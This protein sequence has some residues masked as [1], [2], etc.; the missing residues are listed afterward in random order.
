MSDDTKADP[1][2]APESSPADEL[3][4]RIFADPNVFAD[5]HPL[6]RSLREIAPVYESA[7][8][9]TW[10]L[11][12]YEDCRALLRDNR[13]G[14]AEPGAETPQSSLSS[15]RRR[16]RDPEMRSILFMN[17][18][19]HT[20]IRSLVSRAFTP[21][22]V[23][24]LRPEVETIADS[25]IDDFASDGPVNLLDA[26]AFPLPAN[27]ISALVGVPVE[28]RDW[29]R[30]L[31]GNLTASL[32]LT[33]SEETLSDAEESAETVRAYLA[34]LVAKR[35]ADP[36]DD[37]LSGMI[38]ASDGDDRLSE[39]EIIA[40]TMVIYAAGF[41]TTTHLIC[42]TVLNLL[43]HP[44]QLAMLRADRSLVPRAIEE[45][46][47][48][49]PPVQIDGRTA[50]EDLE[51]GG[52]TIPAGHSVITML[53]GANRDPEIYDD[54]DRFDITRHDQP[55][56]MSF[57]SGIHY[58]L[59]ASLARL[60]GQVVLERLLDR[61][62]EWTLSEEPPW[63]PQIVIRGVERLDVTFSSGG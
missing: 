29:L 49:D 22:R 3:V 16:E 62:G 18:P 48:F 30:P 52:R 11:S 20:R 46:L 1:T 26:M 57:G 25:L 7:L 32:E 37:L 33:A 45:V 17:P 41:E 55:P 43:R 50:F 44:D 42:N 38:A 6:Y 63:R 10:I 13:A 23:D 21:R 2:A 61:F 40:N 28:E 31:V 58:C 60:E 27:V 34:D 5:P 4:L 51:F 47:R 39:N 24:R 12:R 54:P 14:A 19:D 35:R 8:T 59:G 56:V 36:G 9:S 15:A 53:A